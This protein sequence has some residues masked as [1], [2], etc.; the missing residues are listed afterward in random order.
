MH[1][2]FEPEPTAGFTNAAG[3]RNCLTLCEPA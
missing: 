2:I 3:L 1:Y